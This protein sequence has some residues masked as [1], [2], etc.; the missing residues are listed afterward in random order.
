MGVKWEIA[1][2]AVFWAGI[3]F[4]LLSV[5]NIRTLIIKAIPKELRYAVS[6]GI[7]LFITFIGFANA[8]FIV[9]NRATLVG[10]N[11]MNPI[12]I[13]FLAGLVITSILVI[14][15]IKGALIF[16]IVI[17]TLIAIP[18]GRF[19]GDASA[20]NN[21]ISTLVTW[22]GL[23]AYP[24]FSLL[25]KLDFMRAIQFSLFPVIFA[26]LFTDMF[27]SLSTFIGVAEAA[28]LLDEHGEPRN[29]KESLIVDAFATTKV[30]VPEQLILNLQQELRKVEEQE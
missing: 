23:M 21:G 3:I 1:L 27:D 14:K 16:G 10:I 29:I 17:T 11:H 7:G 22:K 13:T 15:R 30:Q 4:I 20:I 25:M 9:D 2:G 26:F 5:F 19:Y 24:D 8:T 18:I 12:V 6:A 28:N